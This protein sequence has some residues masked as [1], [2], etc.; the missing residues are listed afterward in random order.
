VVP[1]SHI[2]TLSVGTGAVI[3]RIDSLLDDLRARKSTGGAFVD[4]E[5]GTGK[6]HL[7][8]L[9]RQVSLDEGYAVAYLNLNGR[10][11]A[12]N[13]P[14][15][16]YHLIASRLRTSSAG[17]GLATI[18]DAVIRDRASRASL[19]T[20][21]D[22]ARYRSELAGSIA[23][24]LEDWDDPKDAP[25][26]AWSVV[27]GSDLVWAD[28]AYKREKALRRIADLGE[29]LSACGAGGLV[30]QLDELET[31]DQL[32]NVRSRIGAYSVLGHLTRMNCVLPILAITDRF[33]QLIDG[34]LKSRSLLADASL[35]GSVRT[36]LQRWQ[37]AA[38][39]IL[40]PA[41]MNSDLAATL[42]ERVIRLYQETYTSS[43]AEVDR[44]GLMNE[45]SRSPWRSPRTLVRRALH[46]LDLL[47]DA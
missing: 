1:A 11:A 17:P 6:T 28:Y 12:V 39:P 37:H 4:G 16:F 25:A 33:A 38:F 31:M 24:L 13:H 34:D 29:F 47:R 35:P 36:F 15:R 26:Y 45:W 40:R 30:L 8:A 27:V 44:T 19:E 43:A 9:I 20:W 23:A 5:W 32:W 21:L 7:L 10:S 14:Q 3:R 41:T 46:E 42:L 2:R 18:I 22:E